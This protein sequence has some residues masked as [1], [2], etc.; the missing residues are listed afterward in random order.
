MS[1]RA[2]AA[3][4]AFGLVATVAGTQVALAGPGRSSGGDHP[5]KGARGG[6][7][8]KSVE[9]IG[10]EPPSTPE[11]KADIYS[12][13]TVKVSYANHRTRTFDLATTS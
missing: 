4:V 5:A 2:L 6:S 7:A 3:G 9:F 11:Q 8:V 12:S 10:M 13:A 1:T